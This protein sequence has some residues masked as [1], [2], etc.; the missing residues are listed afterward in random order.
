MERDNYFI[1]LDLPHT[2]EN[3]A[4]LEAA[5]K[6]KQAEWSRMRNHPSKGILANKYLGMLSDIRQ[7]MLNESLRQ[8]E[9]QA[10]EQIT[11]Q[12]QKRAYAAINKEIQLHAAKGFM[13]QKEFDRLK[14][15]YPQFGEDEI[16]KLLPKNIK[17][18]ANDPA[19]KSKASK[20]THKRDMAE[21][22]S[23][24]EIIGAKSLYDFLGVG[25]HTSPTALQAK[26][27]TLD[28][29]IKR[30]G[31]KTA[32]I[33][34]KGDLIGYCLV[35]LDDSTKRKAYDQALALQG[36]DALDQTLKIFE[37][38]STL[39]AKQFETLVKEGVSLGIDKDVVT[40]HIK[41]Y[42]Q[43]RKLSL[44]VNLASTEGLFPCGSCGHA[45]SPQQARC[46]AC[47]FPTQVEC[48]TCGTENPSHHAQC[49]QCGFAVGDMPLALPLIR[50]ARLALSR[51]EYETAQRTLS[52]AGVFW[53]SNTEIAELTKEVTS[54]SKELAD[55]YTELRTLADGAQYYTAHKKLQA[56]PTGIQNAQWK[57]LQQEIEDRKSEADHALQKARQAQGLANQIAAYQRGL[58][59]ALDCEEA[60]RQLQALPPVPPSQVHIREKAGAVQVEWPA[61]PTQGQGVTLHLLR[62]VGSA[63]AHAQDGTVVYEGVSSPYVDRAVSGGE[64]YY[65]AAYAARQGIF[66]KTAALSDPLLLATPPEQV[67]ALGDNMRIRLSWK[68]QQGSTAPEVL[69][70]G[71]PGSPPQALKDSLQLATVTGNEFVHTDLQNGKTY[72]YT[73]VARYSLSGRKQKLSEAVFVKAQ[74]V[75]PP[76]PITDLQLR[77]LGSVWEAIW[78]PPTQGSVILYR[79]PA[80]FALG[81]NR[82]ISETERAQL[83][84]S[85]TPTEPGRARIPKDFQGHLHVM[86]VLSTLAHHVTGTP[87]HITH[88]PKLERLAIRQ[89]NG[90]WGVYWD[91]PPHS[92]EVHIA[93]G[94]ATDTLS[95]PHRIAAPPQPGTTG[96]MS[97]LVQEEWPQVVVSARLVANKAKGPSQECVQ[98]L[99]KPK[100]HFEVQLVKKPRRKRPALLRLRV[101]RTGSF[102]GAVA[103]VMKENYLPLSREGGGSQLLHR[104]TPEDFT[105]NLHEFEFFM[106]LES[107]RVTK[108]CFR[109]FPDNEVEDL[110]F[111]VEKNQYVLPLK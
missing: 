14:K 11:L 35:H 31:N 80:P 42:A 23:R 103:I 4:T 68:L 78:T 15:T 71:Q 47:G 22:R 86:P 49:S 57:A 107:R 25:S 55:R 39:Y 70:Y 12:A 98:V 33:T 75:S 96:E 94:P 27:K 19:Q 84:T 110:P 5:I 73:L 90:H 60:T 109:L 101:Q 102:E 29:D 108:L 17:I 111:D 20:A 69:I 26:I 100:V 43:K 82:L 56:Q 36:L 99:Q 65:Y 7:V 58:Q 51:Q 93:Y 76:A 8:A 34:A 44:E 54:A 50:D 3:Q 97:L 104:F 81:P 95:P 63:P 67:Q 48:P 88:F 106:P 62:K 74:P 24:L 105:H 92:Q 30:A 28:A 41:A 32:E 87:Q 2:E 16:K 46:T 40:D 64:E 77:H 21:I 89:R 66:S 18:Q 10:A 61:L 79:S 9:A 38:G 59:I 52:E 53:P 91:W 13:T 45:V 1:L 6:K 83:G 37:E 72:G 85:L